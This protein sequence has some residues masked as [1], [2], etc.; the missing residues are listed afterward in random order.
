MSE[1]N[2][3]LIKGGLAS[4]GESDKKAFISAY[5][6]NTRLMGVIGL[7]IHWETGAGNCVSDFHQFFYF[8][9][10]EYGFES[11]R[12]LSGSDELEITFIESTL[13]GG[14][15]GEKIDIT[16]KEACWLIQFYADM[17]RRLSIP[18]PEGKKEY[19]FLIDRRIAMTGAE[20]RKLFAKQCVPIISQYQAVNY[21]LMRCFGK[22][23]DAAAYLSKGA[24]PYDIY[25]EIPEATL[26]KNTIDIF[27]SERGSSYLC[28]SLIEFDASYM[29]IVS[30]ITVSGVKITSFEKRSNMKVSAVE[31]AMMLSRPEF[32][33]VYD[34]LTTP[35]EFDLNIT[36]LTSGTVFTVHENGKLFMSFN[37]NNDHVNSRVFR[38]NEDVSGLYFAADNGQMIIAAYSIKGIHAIEKDLRK[39]SLANSLLPVAKYEFKEPVLYEFIQSDFDDFEEFIE[40]IKD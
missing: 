8:D 10:E 20:K 24:F 36:E 15:G 23:Y 22:D 39:S 17:N 38:L 26:C 21:F 6:T 14:L 31:A 32:V 1:R 13:M 3:K 28:E 33:T 37:K 12:S 16:Q 5:V 27:K 18:L 4:P 19:G 7:Y 9:A 40:Y 30:E 29:L 34:I 11:Y 35:E 25:A 2:F